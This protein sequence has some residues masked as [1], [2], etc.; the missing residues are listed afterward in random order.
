MEPEGL[1]PCSQKS[2]T[3]PYPEPDPYKF[4]VA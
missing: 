2:T 3:D 4:S 1:L